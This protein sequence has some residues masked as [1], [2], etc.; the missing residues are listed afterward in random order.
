MFIDATKDA[1]KEVKKILEKQESNNKVIRV[2]IAGFGWGGPSLGLVLDEQRDDDYT[3]EIEGIKFVAGED[4]TSRFKGFNIEY[5]N[6]FIR[7]G[8]VVTPKGMPASTC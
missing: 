5:V 6:S 7:K 2:N 1:V 8:F 4:L 3:E